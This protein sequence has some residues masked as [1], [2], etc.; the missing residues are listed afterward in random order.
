[1]PDRILFV[2]DEAR[3]LNALRDF[4][5]DSGYEVDCALTPELAKLLISDNSYLAVVSDISFTGLEGREGL[6]LI[7]HIQRHAADTPVIVLTA[8]VSSELEREAKRRGACGF[9][10]KP[11]SL[12]EM[13]E[14]VRRLKETPSPAWLNSGELQ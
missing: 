14:M 5:I 4:F 11:T 10:T 8:H 13:E 9:L 2:D 12:I 7:D 1:M 3:L 6:E